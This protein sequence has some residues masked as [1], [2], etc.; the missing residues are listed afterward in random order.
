MQL[1]A[2]AAQRQ[3]V[4]DDNPYTLDSRTKLGH[5]Y[6]AMGRYDEAR[7]IFES[8]LPAL[9]S[10]WSRPSPMTFHALSGLAEA[11]VKLGQRQDALSRQRE[12]IEFHRAQTDDPNAFASELDTAAAALLMPEFE[13][14]HEPDRAL[15]LAERACALEEADQGNALWRYLR[16]RAAAQHSTGDPAGAIETQRRA[17]SLCP[18]GADKNLEASLR[19][20]E[21]ALR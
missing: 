2:I 17:L 8:T 5:L 12:L 10:F 1:E 11:H 21:S 13:E 14:L 16:T 3:V 6:I 19:V 15:R 20:F 9:Q 7:E 18:D 4:G